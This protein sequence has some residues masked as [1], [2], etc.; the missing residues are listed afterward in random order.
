MHLNFEGP[1]I[2]RGG[3]FRDN[4]PGLFVGDDVKL[5]SFSSFGGYNLTVGAKFEVNSLP[6]I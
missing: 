6:E 4:I 5:G 2:A 1:Q 3:K